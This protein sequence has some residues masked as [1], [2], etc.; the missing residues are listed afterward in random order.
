MQRKQ[1]KGAVILLLFLTM[2]WSVAEAKP[3][4]IGAK[5]CGS[6][7]KTEYLA[8]KTSSHAKAFNLLKPGKRQKAKKLADL[9]PDKDYRTDKKCI[10]CHVT[11][12]R[13]KGG[14]KN[15]ESTPELA[16]IGCEACHGP[17]SKYSILHDE[18]MYG[19]AKEEAAS[20]GQL[21]GADDES[22]CLECHAH[23]DSPF[24]KNIAPKYIFEWQAALQKR[25]A[26]HPK[27]KKSSFAF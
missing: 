17:G 26:Y 2:I 19:F 20:L 16:V 1:H 13:K 22:V 10:G 25:K 7:H 14:Y 8:W 18:K 5:K 27:R 12:Y 9:D 15:L 21:Y 6:C 24:H 4:Y 3:K 23:K 11:G